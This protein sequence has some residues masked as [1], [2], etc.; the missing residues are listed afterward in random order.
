MWSKSNTTSDCEMGESKTATVEAVTY[1]S[2]AIPGEVSYLNNELK[3]KQTRLYNRRQRIHPLS[4][5][6]DSTEVWNSSDN[7]M[8]PGT[9]TGPADTARSY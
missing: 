4:T 8:T 9:V 2:V 7:K 5:V 3:V 6:P 1:S